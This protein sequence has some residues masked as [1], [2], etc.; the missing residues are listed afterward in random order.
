MANPTHAFYGH[1][2]CATMT[3]N[4]LCGA[5]CR[6]LGLRFRAVDNEE[7]FDRDLKGFT[8]RERVDFLAYGNADIEFVRDLPG[9]RGIHIVRDPRD[10]VVSAYY[11][12]L[13]SHPT[14]AWPELEAHRARLQELPQHEGLIEEMQFRRRSF[15]HMQSWDYSQAGILEIRFED[16]ASRSYDTILDAFTHLGLVD[17]GDYHF[18]K[19]LASI[20]REVRAAWRLPAIG[21]SGTRRLPASELLV[22]A[23][24]NRFEARSRGRS[25]GKEDVGNHY[26][27][28]KVGDWA[29]HF[30]PEHKSVFKELY[31]GLVPELGYA[32]SDGW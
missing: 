32:D 27:K 17:D 11:S 9:H 14:A 25:Q 30:T 15:G 1:H 8:A 13:Y 6:R 3:F 12:H 20:L 29:E 5:V 7:Q 24:R 4:T 16:F 22:L 2:K 23:W 19:R 28:G 10:I 26:R 21:G 18:G 31:P